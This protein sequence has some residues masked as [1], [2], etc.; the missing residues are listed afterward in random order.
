[1][2]SILE[3]TICAPIQTLSEITDEYL[4]QRNIIKKKYYTQFL[5]ISKRAWQ[6]IFWN[7]LWVTQNVWQT[8]K[9]GDPYP[10]VDIPKDCLR[11]FSVNT[12][13]DCNKIQPLYYNPQINIISKPV[14]KKCGCE[15]CECGGLCEELNSLTVTTKEV[16]TVNG[17]TYY[18]KIWIKLCPNGDILEYREVP[19]K[20]FNDFIGDGGDFNNDFNNDYDIAANPLANYTIVTETF[21]K[22]I[23]AVT[24]KPCGCPEDTEENEETINCYCSCFLPFFGLRKKKHCDQFLKNI[25]DNE[26]GEFKLSECG[27]KAYFKPSRHWKCVTDKKYPD[28][29]LVNYQTNGINVGAATQVPDYAVSAMFATMDWMSKRFNNVYNS[30]EKEAARIECEREINDV[31]KFLNPL[32]WEFISNVQD[33]KILW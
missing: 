25:N 32:S 33:Q 26:R 9:D 30:S 19:T 11:L 16:F 14:V 10:Y 31:I 15:T 28:F 23:C 6:K 29:L 21:Q 1:M 22:K 4:L 18:E 13:D 24:I 5:A 2:S 12:I 27:T 3:N 8:V 20:K 7:T 17:T